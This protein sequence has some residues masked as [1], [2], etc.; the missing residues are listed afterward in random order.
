VAVTHV[1][2]E[3]S[4]GA[5]PV[6]GESTIDQL[7]VGDGAAPDILAGGVAAKLIHPRKMLVAKSAPI[8]NARNAKKRLVRIE[9]FTSEPKL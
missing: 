8:A 4:V 7:A 5:K 3:S 6:L 9:S 1:T 2:A